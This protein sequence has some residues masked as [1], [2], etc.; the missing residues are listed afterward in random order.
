MQFRDTDYYRASLDRM[1]QA[2]TLS[3]EGDAY[4]LSMY[5]SGLAVE[6]LLRAFRW[7]QD[8]SFEGR[9]DLNDLL[10]A[11]GILRVNDE[12][13]RRR[14][15]DEEEILSAS[16]EFRAAM[17]EILILWHNNLR[18]ASEARLRAH[19]AGLKRVQ[20]IKGDPLKKNASDLLDAAKLIVNKGMV[21]WDSQTKS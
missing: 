2:Q 16:R 1:R 19:L 17:N 20:G 18:F 5:C 9:H 4:A 13:M 7:K 3:K 21:L 10:R 6:C 11:S 15:K 14:G 12:S 8:Q